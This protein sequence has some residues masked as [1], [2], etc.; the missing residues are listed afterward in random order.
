[1]KKM[2]KNMIHNDA[3]DQLECLIVLI[4]HLDFFFSLPRS[5]VCAGRQEINWGG[6]NKAAVIEVRK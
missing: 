6:G 3:D 1:M 4:R 5:S 2:Q